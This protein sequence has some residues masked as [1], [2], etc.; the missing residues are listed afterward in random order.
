MHLMTDF[1]TLGTDPDSVVISLGVAAFNRS[2]ILDKIMFE[3]EFDKQEAMG[4]TIDPDTLAWWK[5]QS[6]DAQKQLIV[7]DF[8]IDFPEFFRLFEEFIDKNL[9][10][11]GEDRKQLKIWGKGADFD[12]VILTDIY[13]R[14]HPQGKRALPWKFWGV[15]CYRMFESMTDCGKLA[16][17]LG[18]HH[19]ALDDAIFQAECVIKI[20]QRS[21]KDV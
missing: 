5:N 21:K 4:R 15:K 18:T 3:F 1:E 6:E 16:T 13:R 7:S 8:A 14:H 2:G 19:N 10:K 17:R 20:L 9:A 12:V 11:L